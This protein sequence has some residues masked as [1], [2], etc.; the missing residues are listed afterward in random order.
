MR[1]LNNSL[2]KLQVLSIGRKYYL[3]K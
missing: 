3:E 2:Q 1:V